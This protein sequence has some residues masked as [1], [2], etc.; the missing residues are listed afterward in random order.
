MVSKF[1]TLIGSSRKALLAPS[2]EK[3]PIFFGTLGQETHKKITFTAV[4]DSS[5]IAETATLTINIRLA[6]H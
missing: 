4:F 3:A 1:C 5:N 6:R 2:D